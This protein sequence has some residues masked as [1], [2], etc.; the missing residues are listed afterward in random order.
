[1]E[2]QP[3]GFAILQHLQVGEPTAPQL[4]VHQPFQQYDGAYSFGDS[5][6]SHLVPIPSLHD[7]EESSFPGSAPPSDIVNSKCVLG[8]K[9]IDS[10]VMIKYEVDKFTHIWSVEHLFGQSHIY[11]CF[12]GRVSTLTHS[13][14]NQ[15]VRIIPFWTRL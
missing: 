10:S 6:E 4:A 11:P 5:A 12:M 15:G 2:A 3:L 14:L 8:V 1:M 7:R 9:S 13:H